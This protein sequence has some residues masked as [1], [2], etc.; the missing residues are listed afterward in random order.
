M[1][2]LLVFVMP[3]LALA[4]GLALEFAIAGVARERLQSAADAGALAGGADL[5]DPNVVKPGYTPDPTTVQDTANQDAAL[6]ANLNL[7]MSTPLVYPTP[8]PIFAVFGNV[9]DPTDYNCPFGP[10]DDQ[11]PCNTLVVTIERSQRNNNPV[12]LRLGPFLGVLPGN[13]AATSRAT[14]DQRVYGFRP[15]GNVPIPLIPLTV[16]ASGSSASWTTQAQAAAVPNVNDNF[17]VDPTT[18]QV[19]SGPDGI[20]EVNVQAPYQGGP[21]PGSSDNMAEMNI[22]SPNTMAALIIRGLRPEDLTAF[23]GQFAFGSS[24]NIT[25]QASSTVDAGLTGALQEIVGANRVW[26]LYSSASGTD[27]TIT[28][29]V[30]GRVAQATTV[31]PG[32]LVLAVQPCVYATPTALVQAGQPLN[33]FVAKIGLTR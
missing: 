24:G 15:V 33:P 18:G 31:P 30:A 25:V 8:T 10:N 19:T 26:P 17:T 22:T 14:L 12:P 6:Y 32:R 1:S 4:I 11:N 3:L 13:V 2:S 27:Y 5:L 16:L 28:Q 23:G 7:M 9:A 21:A 20:P 29:F